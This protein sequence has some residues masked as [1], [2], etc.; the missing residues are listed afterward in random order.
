MFKTIYIV[1]FFISFCFGKPFI[2]GGL[3][4]KIEDGETIELG[5]RFALEAVLNGSLAGFNNVRQ[6]DGII[7]IVD[8]GH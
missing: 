3:F 1:L 2:L 5:V 8:C 7:Q 4:P 6:S